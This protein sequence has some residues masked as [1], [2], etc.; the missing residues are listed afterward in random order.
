M[1]ISRLCLKKKAVQAITD[2]YRLYSFSEGLKRTEDFFYKRFTDIYIELV[3]GRLKG[4]SGNKR[5]RGSAAGTLQK[6]LNI[7]L[8]LFAPVMPFITEEVWSWVFAGKENIASIHIAPWPGDRD[9]AGI[10]A[11]MHTDC[12][13][14]AKS[15][16]HRI[17]RL[18]NLGFRLK[19]SA[20]I[21]VI[22][23]K[24]LQR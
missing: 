17:N 3:K 10:P 14:A 23:T 18:L 4:F 6:A 20:K 22:N 1:L 9:F 19:S 13:N 2:D 11:V 21:G 15:V 5:A 24:N 7:L 8:R 12:F 16:M